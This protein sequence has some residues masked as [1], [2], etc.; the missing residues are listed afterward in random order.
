M[1]NA[2]LI[3]A[4]EAIGSRIMDLTLNMDDIRLVGAVE[5][6]GHPLVGKDIGEIM[7]LGATGIL[8]SDNLMSVIGNADVI[9]HFASH[10]MIL[11]HSRI[12]AENNIPI[13]IGTKG[14]TQ[15]ELESIRSLAKKTKCVL[16]PKVSLND[17]F[18]RSA[19][20]AAKW[21]VRQTN[22]LYDLQDVT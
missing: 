5:R 17:N 14:F 10:D 2:V 12:A 22:G 11:A 8:V 19:V 9:L 15:D 7:N 4:G 20:R 16:V 21:I 13:V 6:E 1:I 3:G 18:V